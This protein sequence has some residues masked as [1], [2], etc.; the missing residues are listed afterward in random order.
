MHQISYKK[1]LLLTAAAVFGM[2]AFSVGAA[3]AASH[4]GHGGGHLTAN[5]LTDTPLSNDDI[6]AA[7]FDPY[8][9]NG[10]HEGYP[11]LP[12]G[13]HITGSTQNPDGTTTYQFVAFYDTNGNPV[14][15]TTNDDGTVTFDDDDHDRIVCGISGSY[16]NN[17]HGGPTKWFVNFQVQVDGTLTPG[18]R[19]VP[20]DSPPDDSDC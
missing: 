2:S 12:P 14:P 13:Q 10:N 20:P 17:N 8:D 5:H 3:Y 1:Q 11:T 18:N 6:L 16:T 7:P 9:P 15:V 4:G 19:S